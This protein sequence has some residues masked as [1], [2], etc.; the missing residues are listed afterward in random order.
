MA[1]NTKCGQDHDVNFGVAEEPEDVLEQQWITAAC[2]VKESCAKITV[3][4]K[5]GDCTRQNG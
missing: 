2:H 4:E 1:D 3:S 5:H